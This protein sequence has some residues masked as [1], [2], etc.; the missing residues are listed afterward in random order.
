MTDAYNDAVRSYMEG[1]VQVARLALHVKQNILYYMQAI[2][3]FEPHDQRYF[4]LH[5]VEVPVL[6]ADQRVTIAD[7]PDTMAFG[8]PP[9]RRLPD[10][11]GNARLPFRIATSIAFE[12][13]LTTEPLSKV[14]DLDELIGFKGNY[15]IFPLLK[16]NALTDFIAAPYIDKGFDTVVDPDE[17]GNWTLDEFAE[18][19]CCLKKHLASEQFEELKPDLRQQYQV[20]LTT[21]H[22]N[23]ELITVP[24]GSL[25]IEPLPGVRP[26]ME[27][28][29]LMHR[30][31]DVKK[32]QA[33]VRSAELENIRRAARILA[34]EYADPD[35]EKTVLVQGGDGRVDVDV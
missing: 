20:L 28:Y 8:A 26:V 9:H 12:E 21:P 3:T 23:G 13:E 18:Y 5:K 19:V 29:K 1:R 33:E 11:A 24:T 16:G 22:R 27:A 10:A 2:W 30:A 25:Y 15:M 31:V 34:K 4:R 32:V 35:I 7:T 6:E 17:P 14:A